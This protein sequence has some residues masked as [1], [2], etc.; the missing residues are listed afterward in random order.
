MGLPPP[1]EW[2]QGQ[3]LP[4]GLLC[5]SGAETGRA[6]A[7]PGRASPQT[8]ARNIRKEPLSVARAA[9][10]R[11]LAKGAKTTSVTVRREAA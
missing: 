5:V 6:Q 9:K 4:A 3:A 2:G 10:T 7:G 1:Q 8:L 11:M